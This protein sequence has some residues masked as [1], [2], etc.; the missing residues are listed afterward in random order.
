MSIGVPSTGLLN[1]LISFIIIIFNSPFQ[2]FQR[3]FTPYLGNLLR[4]N[5]TCSAPCLVNGRYRHGTKG[6]LSFS[7]LPHRN[8]RLHIMYHFDSFHVQ[9]PPKASPKVFSFLLTF[10]CTRFAAAIC[11]YTCSLIYELFLQK[12]IVLK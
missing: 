5:S 6:G 12:G 8:T 2:V 7:G 3:L 1:L 4:L 9:G 10:H 11:A